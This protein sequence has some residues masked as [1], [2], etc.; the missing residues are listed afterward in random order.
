M[1]MLRPVLSGLP[2]LLLAVP[3]HAQEFQFDEPLVLVPL[4]PPPLQLDLPD[5][6]E[7]VPYVK[8]DRPRLAP[9]VRAMLEAAM[10]TDDS[11]SVA[12]LVKF[13]QQTQP[14][15]KDEIRDMQRAFNDRRAKEIA[16]K[17]EA[18]L[19]RIR[20][21]GVLELWK[22]QIE[23]GAFRS[24]GNTD[25]FGY[26]AALKFNRKGIKWEHII[27]ANADYQEDRGTITR[28]QYSASYQP[29]YTLNEGFFTY[30]RTQY[31]RDRIQGFEDRYT[32]SGG[33]GYRVL[34]RPGM[35]LALEA[36][37]AF[38][39]TNYVDDI[40]QTTWSVLTSLDFDWTINP[41]IKLTQDASS[42][43]GSDNNTFTSMT[44]IEAGMM[45]GLKAKLSYSIEHET[46]PP[47]GSLKTDTISRFS[48]VYGF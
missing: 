28:E 14:Y 45:K 26:T 30:G 11:A 9:A 35:M 36:G 3:V 16:A 46:R 41:T 38:R 48:L 20:A 21:S 31:E 25:N 42:Y 6:P 44:A 8:A 5:Y 7:F 39:A 27:Q 40:N 17:T 37:P 1:T 32:L 22:G 4:P 18:D 43:I 34:N 13:A 2:V 12:A 33:L 29:R 15:D 19:A 24:T 23:V 47:S 10:K